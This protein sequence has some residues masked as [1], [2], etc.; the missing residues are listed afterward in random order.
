MT[1]YYRDQGYIRAQVGE[2]ELK[3]SATRR[4]RRPAGSSCGF[5]S[6]KGKRYR[7][8]T[9]RRSPATRSS[10]A[11]RCKP[12]FKLKNGE[13]YSQK[14]VRKGSRRPRRST[15]PAATWS[16]PATRTT[17]SATNPIRRSPTLRRRS[18][19]VDPNSRAGPPTVD[20][21][22]QIQEG[23]QYFVNRI[24]FTGNTTTRD[25]VIRRELR[26]LR[27][28]RLQHRSAEV[29]HQAPESA[30]ILQAARG[31]GQGRQRRQDARTPTTRSTS[32]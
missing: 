27:E 7:V 32:R 28:R 4:T 31:A 18:R 2:P 14:Q 24:I 10:R 21:T 8:G 1:E 9:F 19:R 26:L 22:L 16:S 23:K 15:A 25:N 11:R 12:L 5:R 30:R 3:I 20:V 13:Y 17:S 29:Q 6:P